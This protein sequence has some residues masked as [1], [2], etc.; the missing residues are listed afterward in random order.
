MAW[1]GDDPLTGDMPH[2]GI[3]EEEDEQQAQ[4]LAPQYTAA[5]AVQAR[6]SLSLPL[7]RATVAAAPTAVVHP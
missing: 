6:C 7:D 2:R 4:E 1:A 5:P 3:V